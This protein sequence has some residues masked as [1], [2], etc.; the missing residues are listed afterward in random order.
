MEA[1]RKSPLNYVKKASGCWY[2]TGSL[3]AYGYG[4]WRPGGGE[5]DQ[6]AHRAVYAMLIGPIP[7]DLPLDHQCHNNDPD[8]PGGKCEHRR[9]VRPG[10][11]HCEPRTQQ[12]NL[13]GSRH[14]V[15][16]I[17]AAKT[18]CPHGHPYDE[19][20]THRLPDGSRECRAC[21]RIKAHG[22]R[23]RT[24]IA[25]PPKRPRVAECGNGHPYDDVNTYISRGTRT[26]RAC[27]AANEAARRQRLREGT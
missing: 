2:W 17:N 22:R 11:G 3:D 15:P 9:C 26:C 5:R 1:T 25:T 6:R 16:S 20:N 18:K 4:R 10:Q 24:P 21:N 13:R 8:C 23:R 14:T 7:G 27:H 19:E 12:Q